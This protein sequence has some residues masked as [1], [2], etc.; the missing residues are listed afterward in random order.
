RHPADHRVGRDIA[1]NH[2]ALADAGALGNFGVAAA[3][4]A[5][6]F[7]RFMDK[8]R[9]G[10]PRRDHAACRLGA[11][12]VTST[13]RSATASRTSPSWKMPSRPAPAAFF[14]AIIS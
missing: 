10:K 1:R 12:S 13:V 11:K 2:R 14:S 7:G 9:L 5:V 4:G 8:R 3:G 6:Y